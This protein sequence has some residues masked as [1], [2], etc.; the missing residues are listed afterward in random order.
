LYID[1]RG[2]AYG[3]KGDFERA[4]A[5]YTAAIAL[6]PQAAST[7]F[8][9]GIAQLYL[10]ALPKALSD[11]NQAAELE[12]KDAIMAIWL[13]I[14]GKRSKLP[15]RLSEI[16]G[17]IDM[18]KWPGPLVRLYLGQLTS[19]AVLAAADDPDGE[20]KKRQVCQANFYGGELALQ[21][22]AK[23]DATRLFRLAAAGCSPATIQWSAANAELR[24]LGAP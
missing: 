4:V 14:V 17:K 15:S 9:R 10:G 1:G 21:A 16:V 7:I 18:T 23:D 13:D 8:H 2:L 11:V 22:E 12:P 20:T 5:D 19:E 24:A 6:N 3:G